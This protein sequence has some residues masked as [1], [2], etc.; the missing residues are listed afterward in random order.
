MSVVRQ[1]WHT[2]GRQWRGWA[3]L[4]ACS[5]LEG[6]PAFLSGVLIQSAVDKGFAAGRPLVGA[7][8]LGAFGAIAV[9]GAF[10]ARLVWSTVGGV[11][12][13]VR[14]AL[15]GVVVRGVLRDSTG[16]RVAPDASAVA[17][18][19]QHVE[20]VRDATAGMLV[21][22]R[23]MV[24]TAVAAVLGVAAVAGDLV[25]AVALPVAVA[26]AAFLVL[27]PAL[28][29]GQRRLTLA[30]EATAQAAG[31]ALAG[32]PDIAACAA[33]DTASAAVKAAADAQAAAATR[34]ASASAA[35]VAVVAVGAFLPVVLVP[36]FGAGLSPGTL[37][38]VLVYLTG[39]LYPA[40]N[41]LAA[42]ASTV[43]LRLLVA[44]RRLGEAASTPALE[45]GA[46]TPPTPEV[47][48]RGLTHRW[49]PHA[50]PVLRDLDLDL[51]P[52]DHL[53]VIGPS[54]I[55]K[56]T[57]AALMT[58]LLP[59]QRGSVTIGG[60]P[61]HDVDHTTLVAFTP[62]EAYVFA[63][64]VRENLSLLNPDATDDDLRHAAQE[65]GAGRLLGR[66]GGLDGEIDH[67]GADLDP[68]ERQLLALARVHATRSAI[69]VLDEA[70][71]HLDPRAEAAA[72]RAFAARG[73]ILVVIA[74][75]MSSAAR[76]DRVLLLDG[77]HTVL[78]APA[79]L[80]KHCTPYIDLLNAWAGYADVR[81]ISSVGSRIDGGR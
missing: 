10:G 68:A 18:I 64:T 2:L 16:H 59:V 9:V 40:L 4:L 31:E 22:A 17:R 49:G 44:L 7:A 47:A 61:I 53:C 21:Q 69:V 80:E 51:C 6:L 67:A 43:V 12:E 23:G 52:G 72:E 45:P 54:G 11:V 29:R 70:T 15:V 77:R 66:L 75:R 41:G 14:D 20:V 74:H 58:G 30:D 24:V 78:G 8:W 48:I 46:T 56:S 71:S 19:T 36:A 79:D 37:L 57:L 3:V 5:L 42:T 13:P 27:L 55:G 65:V 25:W 73:G 76:A 35:R 50:E 60:V 63:G 38:G 1:Y 62:Q 34:L 81:R 26:V 39:T 32:L 33:Q 28:A